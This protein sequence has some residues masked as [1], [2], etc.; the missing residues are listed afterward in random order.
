M[1]TF[2]SVLTAA[3]GLA[4][5]LF[6]MNLLGNSLERAAGGR[7]QKALEKMTSNV[8]K[9]LLL[10]LVVTAAIQSSS[11]TTVIVVGLV[12][13][14][15]LKLRNAIGVIMGAN[16]GTTVTSLIV[17]LA[18]PNHADSANMILKFLK[19]ETFTPVI[20]VVAIV[21]IMSTKKSKPRMIA[22]IMFGFA[23]LFNGMMIMTDALKPLSESDLF[24]NIFATLSNPLLGILVGTVVTAIIQSS[25]A[26][27]AILQTT[28]ATG[29]VPFSAAVPIILGQNIGTCVTS[30]LSSIGANKNARRAAMVHLYFNIIGTIVFFIGIYLIQMFIRFPFWNDPISMTG[31]SYVHIT[32]N[33]VTTILFIPFTGLLEKLAVLTVRGKKNEGQDEEVPQVSVLDERFLRT[34]QL[35]LSHSKEIVELMGAYAK[36]NFKRSVT[37]F[38][39]FDLKKKEN[40]LE[41]EDAIDR[42]EDRLNRYMVDMTNQ[43]LSEQDSRTITYQMKL[44]VEFERIGDYAI[45]VLELAEQ[46]HQKGVKLSDKAIEELHAF[47][48]AVTEIIE[49][50]LACV[51]DNDSKLATRVEPLEEIVDKMEDTLKFRHI[52]RLKNGQCT[53]DGG[54]VFLELLT[55]LERI[56]DHCSNIAVYVIGYQHQL[57]TLDRH[58]YIKQMH[59]GEDSEYSRVFKEYNEKYFSRI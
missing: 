15:I 48:D 52:E 26:S 58:E 5:F 51:K 47:S 29:A 23:I 22:E 21:V 54:L 10:G 13:A 1:E 7:M 42:M 37:M 44:I 9:S 11:A 19:P 12:N 14:G 31:I 53:I 56:S 8:F 46:L 18:D 36:K 40:I 43:E 55:N 20:A 32:F 38:Q 30:L 59:E 25:S 27:V 6:G 34:P 35:A 50:A 2:L 41:F 16:I 3:G 57:D 49:L 33:V 45:N 28:A 17:S 39:S 24:R 4:F